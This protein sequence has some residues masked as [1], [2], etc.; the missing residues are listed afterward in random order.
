MTNDEDERIV[1]NTN[2]SDFNADGNQSNVIVAFINNELENN[3]SELCSLTFFPRLF[4][5]SLMTIYRIMDCAPIS[6]INYFLSLSS[7][8]IEMKI[9]SEFYIFF[10]GTYR[11]CRIGGICK[12]VKKFLIVLNEHRS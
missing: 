11:M 9:I 7:P 4:H 3:C 8:I 1:D 5:L 12:S 2:M 6:V 10:W